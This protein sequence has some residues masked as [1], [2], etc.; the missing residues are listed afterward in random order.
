VGEYNSRVEQV[1]QVG[2]VV[3]VKQVS[4]SSGSDRS[5]GSTCADLIDLRRPDRPA[6]TWSTSTDLNW[7]AQTWSTCWHPIDL[8]RWIDWPPRAALRP[9]P[10]ARSA[11]EP[12]Q[13]RKAAAL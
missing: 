4:G 1:E 9:G 2:R 12:R 3:Q 11:Y 6:Q 13:G 5:T 8:I 10:C 7:P